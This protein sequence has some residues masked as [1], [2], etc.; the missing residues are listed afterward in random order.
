MN[1][2]LIDECDI[3]WSIDTW[4]TPDRCRGP[5]AGGGAV[6]GPSG[7]QV[8]SFAQGTTFSALED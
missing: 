3:I 4:D 1:V 6:Y 5:L 8:Q 7:V 2:G